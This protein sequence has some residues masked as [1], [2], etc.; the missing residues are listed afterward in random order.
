MTSEQRKVSFPRQELV[1]AYQPHR[2]LQDAG[3]WAP[4]ADLFTENAAYFDSIFGWNYGREAIRA[5]LLTSTAGTEDWSFPETW[6]I[7][8]GDRLVFHWANR[9]PGQ[10]ADGSYYEFQGL[11]SLL[12][13]GDGLWREQQDIYDTRAAFALLDEWK[14]D[15]PES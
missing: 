6:F 9:L 4:I 12:Y 10:R 7:C 11:S 8:E 2:R 3:D 14:Q 5:F 1:E 15:H 13:A